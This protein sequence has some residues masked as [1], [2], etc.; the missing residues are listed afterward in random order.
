MGLDLFMG[1]IYSEDLNYLGPLI[2]KYLSGT[3]R[4]EER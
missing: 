3:K 2:K 1:E 4:I